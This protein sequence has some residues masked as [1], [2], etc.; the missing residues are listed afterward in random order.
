M[1]NPNPTNKFQK[2]NREAAK[3]LGQPNLVS[4]DLKTLIRE[5]AAEAGFVERVPVLDAEGRP[6]GRTELATSLAGRL[7]CYAV[8][9][10]GGVLCHNG[11]K[12]HPR[13]RVGGIVADAFDF[14]I[15][16]APPSQ[17]AAR[18]K[19]ASLFSELIADSAQDR[20]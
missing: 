10:C 19:K 3:K 4:R 5:A 14:S 1:A 16:A 17:V 13:R 15:R 11:E 9:R 18:A 8:V 20:H 12:W 7:T 2:G 6:T